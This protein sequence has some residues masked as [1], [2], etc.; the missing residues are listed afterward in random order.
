MK[1]KVG[2]WAVAAALIVPHT[3]SAAAT[4]ESL[5][6]LSLPNTTITAAE[7][8]AA[9]AFS[10]GGGAGKGKAASFSDVPAFCRVAFTVKPSSDSDIRIELWMPSS[11]WNHKFEAN[12]NGGWAG[13]ITP[14]TLATGVKLGYAASMTDTGHEG[15]SAS[16]AL[17]HPEKVVDFGY[18][19]VHEMAVKSKAFINAF[20]G[21]NPKYSY[22]NGC[23]Q[24]GRQGLAEAQRYPDDF[25]GIV[26]GSPGV[27]WAGRAMHSVWIA[28]VVH[29]D[30]QSAI[31]QAKFQTVHSAVLAAC[32]ALDGVKDGVLEDPTRC[33][34]DPKVLECK[35]ADA[36]DCL[37]P[38][39]VESVRRMYTPV[40]NSRTKH[41]EFAGFEP[42][43]EMG[44]NTM[45]GPQP[46]G[47]GI[48]LFKYVVFKD[49][50]WDYKSMNWDS[51]VEA[52]RK[53]SVDMDALNP[54]VS[55]FIAHGKIIQYHGWADPQI[56]PG[57]GLDYY[58]SVLEKLG[59]TSKVTP[60]Y[61]LYMVPGMAHCGGGDGTS[62]FDM[63]TALE[64]WVESKKAPDQI[65]ASRLRNGQTDRTRPLCPYPQVAV[66]KGSGS[67]D[68]AVNF[69]CKAQ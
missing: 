25:D 51:D 9:G 67:T 2:L 16:F 53:A 12:G 27:N 65:V 52:T 68:D 62:T 36:P 44:W 42:G 21:E 28:Q 66:Y 57:S 4:C 55:K 20:Y 56:A 61:R 43:S 30:E 63:L 59:G 49:P 58:K 40:A 34:F 13:S 19:S 5:S 54:D 33:K 23:S 39:Q 38:P 64:Q 17:G 8:V 15:G 50:N 32:D 47:L 69:S 26:A 60:S 37:T 6:S 11:G 22:W 41:V 10:P 14:A 45:A 18:R 24:G 7:S 31:P 29:K 48:D 35:G 1:L 46:F 3:A